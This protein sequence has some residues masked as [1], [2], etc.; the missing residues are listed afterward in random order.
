MKI[1]KIIQ[2]VAV[3]TALCLP[4]VA[5]KD[6]GEGTESPED[7]A[8]EGDP[9]EE[10]Q[11]IP[12]DIQGEVDMVMQPLTDLESLMADLET[13]PER[14]SIS[15]ADLKGMVGASFKDGTVEVSADLDVSEEARAEIKAML[16][17][18]KAIGE[19]LKNIAENTKMATVNVVG[20]GARAMPLATKL[21]G[22]LS[23]KAKFAKGEEKAK[24]ESDLATVQQIQ[25][26]VT[27]LVDGAKNQ[28]LEIPPKAAEMGAKFTASLA[29]G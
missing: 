5:C 6:D 25:G 11:A 26:D 12:A 10:L 15:A 14:L 28:I 16:E 23:A 2:S 20:H 29:A 9:L 7:G 8:E 24:L 19:G 4:L 3:M 18:A 13:A 21:T 22:K 1:N 17:K 27:G